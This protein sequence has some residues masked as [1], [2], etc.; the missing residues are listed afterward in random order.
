VAS[1]RLLLSLSQALRGKQLQAFQ[2]QL[3]QHAS[4]HVPSLP[5]PGPPIPAP[6][7]SSAEG[8]KQLQTQPIFQ[9]DHELAPSALPAAAFEASASRL[10]EGKHVVDSK[11]PGADRDSRGSNTDTAPESEE[12]MNDPEDVI[13]QCECVCE[14]S[15]C[16]KHS[17]T[18]W[19][20][21]WSEPVADWC[22]LTS[23]VIGDPKQNLVKLCRMEEC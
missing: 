7:S 6:A 17:V 1:A 8:G 22:S 3:Q 4:L 15:I 2:S 21:R 23:E 13:M 18:E 16:H 10:I 11:L 14:C 5:P 19:D 20:R 9:V 12:L